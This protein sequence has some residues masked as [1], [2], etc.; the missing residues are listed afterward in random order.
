MTLQTVARLLFVY[1]FMVVMAAIVT[2]YTNDY[3]PSRL[4]YVFILKSTI[5]WAGLVWI[6]VSVYLTLISESE[7]FTT[8]S[9]ISFV[10]GSLMV[11]IGLRGVFTDPLWW[12]GVR[13]LLYLLLSMSAVLM[14]EEI[15]RTGDLES[16]SVRLSEVL[17]RQQLRQAIDPEFWKH[18]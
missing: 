18:R 3:R 2:A 10:I 6:S 17:S 9:W 4:L 7:D 8:E 16:P 1:V 5:L 12:L 14:F 15:R 13:T 11:Y